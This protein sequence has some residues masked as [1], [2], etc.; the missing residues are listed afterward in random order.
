MKLLGASLTNVFSF[1]SADI[2]LNERGLVL[3]TG[4]DTSRGGSNGAGK[5]SLA[6]RAL[7]WGLYGA[8][9]DDVRADD[10][11][12]RFHKDKKASVE[13]HFEDKGYEYRIIRQRNPAKLTLLGRTIKACEWQ[14][15]SHRL[16]TETQ[17][18]IN[19][20]L[21]RSFSTF[22]HAD[23]F[24]QG[25]NKNFLYLSSK[26]QRDII[27][28]ILPI[29]I[30]DKWAET[31][32]KAYQSLTNK[33]STLQ[34]EIHTQKARWEDAVASK[35]QL[36][37]SF[38]QWEKSRGIE[39]GKIK[40]QIA[41]VAESEKQYTIRWE[42]IKVKLD[43]LG[44]QE[45]LPDARILC[46]QRQNLNAE[47]NSASLVRNSEKFKIKSIEE[48]ICPTCGQEVKKEFTDKLLAEQEAL[49]KS[50]TLANNGI[51]VLTNKLAKYDVEIED[52]QTVINVVSERNSQ[53]DKY[54]AQLEA[55]EAVQVPSG[56][57]LNRQCTQ[58]YEEKNPVEEPLSQVT[59]KVA[60][61][62]KEL[63]Q[64]REAIKKVEKDKGP[65]EIWNTAFKKDI[66][67]ALFKK[68]C[69]FLN[70]RVTYHLSELNNSHLHAEF[71]TLKELKSGESRDGL[72]VRCW[73]D[74]GGE[75]FSSLSGGEK[76]MI[77]FATGMAIADL[78][79]S[80]SESQ[81]NIMVLDEPFLYLDNRNCENIVNYLTGSLAKT[82]STIFLISNEDS[83]KALI[84]NTIHVVKK[85][86]ISAV[87]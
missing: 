68:V 78:A 2:L 29:G 61:L 82:R 63:D 87:V 26:D 80:Q 45:S 72:N 36:Q 6:S 5:S 64:S 77:S 79:E 49:Q 7:S 53:R 84:P 75:S 57:E 18:H 4:S 20:I 56:I 59:G 48:E 44:P 55:M 8:S 37:T 76:Q 42:G 31:S 32:K 39:I 25:R 30:I 28:E 27:E 11:V 1:V 33:L 74:E 85:D 81:C 35:Q 22:C 62:S 69:K 15:L 21:G 17:T 58:K 54:N 40:E 16:E 12:N 67:N 83:L 52:T 13:I 50:I 10:V 71:A 3:V 47:L 66:K 19:R 60:T 65:V 34:G 24:G 23:V 51:Q 38:N 70:G 41:R 73:N 86:G 46:G 14:D 9:V 43:D